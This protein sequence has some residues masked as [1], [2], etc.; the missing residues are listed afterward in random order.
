MAGWANVPMKGVFYMTASLTTQRGEVVDYEPH[1]LDQIFV[2]SSICPKTC[3]VYI[4]L[5]WLLLINVVIHITT[6]HPAKNR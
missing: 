1:F 5:K 4:G 2:L 6:S 3:F